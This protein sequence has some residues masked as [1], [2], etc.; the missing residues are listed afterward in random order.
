VASMPPSG[1]PQP[2]SGPPSGPYPSGPPAYAPQYAAAG[3]AQ[4][5]GVARKRTGWLLLAQVLGIIEGIAFLL[6]GVGFILLGVA[7]RDELLKALRNAQNISTAD[8]VRFADIATGVFVGVGVFLIVYFAFF[9]WASVISGRPSTGARVV[10]VILDIILLLL[11]FA[12]FAG[13]SSAGTGAY[14]IGY[15]V[16]WA[17]QALILIGMTFAGTRPV[18]NPYPA[19]R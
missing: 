18:N 15:V 17:W 1:P 2:P 12:G 5:G 16:F 13:R 10:V 19:S 9:I 6:L 11:S 8:L 3:P 14:L 4:Y 7:A